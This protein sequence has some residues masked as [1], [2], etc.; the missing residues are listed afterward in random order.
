MMGCSP[1]EGPPPNIGGTSTSSQSNTQTSQGSQ[2]AGTGGGTAGPQGDPFLVKRNLREEKI[3]TI[4]DAALATA[5]VAKRDAMLAGLEACPGLP[6]GL[7]R[8]LRAEL[9]PHECADA[10]VEP[11]LK[12]P[13]TN[14]KK[15]AYFALL[16]QALAARLARTATNPPTMTAPFERKRVQEFLRGPM[17]AWMTDQGRLIEEIGKISLELPFY[18]RGVVAVEAGMADLRVVEVVRSAP[19]PKEIGDD[20]ELRNIYY[21]EL[22][23]QLEPRK[24]RGR[25]ASLVG[26]RD[27]A[28]AGVI[29]NS[30]VDKAR[31]L[32]SKLYGGRRVD[33]L[34][35]LLLPALPPASA[36]SVEERLAAK[37]PTFTAG[38]LLDPKAATK[39]GTLRALLEQGLPVQQRP[40]LQDPALP[41]EIHALHARAHLELG[42][43][44]W[45]AVD[46]DRTIALTS[47]NEGRTPE[48]SL[49][50]A[51]AIGLSDGPEDAA[52]MML[53]A[54]LQNIGIG[55]VAAL[56]SVAK[57]SGPNGGLATYNAATILQIAA[58]QGANAAYWKDVADRFQRAASM[59][60]EGPARASASEHAKAAQAVAS[61]IK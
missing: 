54:P 3:P 11:V 53:K 52:E 28:A 31:A 40:A 41:A 51:T 48:A 2:G 59:L 6:V 26:L 56:D 30:R 21:G 50:L 45:R 39:P 9:A 27:L 4:D 7:I 10:I 24:T 17:L 55:R 19:V 15:P 25:D 5:D 61:A 16:G 29:K 46:F 12:A 57:Q 42:R 20:E 22:D 43:L 58:P 8:G 23:Q 1:K 14:I 33:A 49:L 37:L 47:K 60:P 36:A 34:D 44:Y 18:A 32:L 35:A 13:P 38:F